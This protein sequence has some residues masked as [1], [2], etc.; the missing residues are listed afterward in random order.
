MRLLFIYYQYP[1][2]PQGSY[3]QE[4]INQIAARVSQAYLLASRYPAGEFKKPK[5]LT[6]FWL[7]YFNLPFLNE[8]FFI[9]SAL[10]KVIF[11]K[12]LHQVDLVNA[13]GP[14]G[15]LAGWYLKRKYKLPLICTIEL[16]NERKTLFN[17]LVYLLSRFLITKA[18]VDKF[19]C[20]SD[21]YWKNYLRKWGID[22][23]RVTIIPAGIDTNSY[24]PGIDGGE[25]K[26]KYSP[27]D[28]LIVFAKPLYYPNTEAAKLLVRSIALLKSDFKIKLLIGG[29]NGKKEVWLLA[30][31]LG[32]DDHVDFMLPTP[33]PEI[34]KY[35]AA[36]DL[37]VLPFTY[38]PTTSRSL[39]EAMAM[40]KP[41]ITS[42]LGEIKEILKDR[43]NAI[44]VEPIPEKISI[45]IKETFNDKNLSDK[46][47]SNARRLVE[48]KFSLLKTSKQTIEFFKELL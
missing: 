24:N 1:L 29:G 46:I 2:Y 21:Y 6:I 12:E 40:K 32:V 19:I 17:N 33:F 48:D 31:S 42:P 7:P 14:R 47:S 37:V 27:N 30:E 8:I 18:P 34:P 45:A 4:F 36:A 13:V 16:I 26:K 28:P 39:L 25:I 5:N 22:K 3:F 11:T 38:A 35:I 44:L 10:I 43:K 9:L 23:N 15:I 20:W 41:I